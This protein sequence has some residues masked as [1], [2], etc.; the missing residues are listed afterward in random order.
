M[1]IYITTTKYFSGYV[2][3]IFLTINYE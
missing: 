2:G 3:K 1:S